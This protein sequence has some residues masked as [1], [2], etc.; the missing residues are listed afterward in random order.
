MSDN[1]IYRKAKKKVKAKKGF[2]MHFLAYA[3]MVI[4]M[5]IIMKFENDSMLPAIILALS[6]GIGIAIH[7]FN[8]FGTEQLGFLGFNSNWEEDALERE[9]EKLERKRELKERLR[10]EEG[11]LEDDEFLEL[12]EME[13]TKVKDFY[14]R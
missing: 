2:F 14:N 4:M 9:V 6:W 7:Y 1:D 11:L 8:V 10:R 5:T 3:F 12:K 13:K